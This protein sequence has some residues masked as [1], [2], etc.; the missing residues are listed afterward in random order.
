MHC[1][2][3]VILRCLKSQS[4]DP[5]TTS[6]FG[7]FQLLSSMWPRPL[8]PCHALDQLSACWTPK[9][10]KKKKS[11]GTWLQPSEPDVTGVNVA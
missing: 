4:S 5:S 7:F 11:T 10:L 6:N 3:P 2:T 8:S 1:P 9:K